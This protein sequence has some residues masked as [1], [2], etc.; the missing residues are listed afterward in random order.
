MKKIIVVFALAIQT[1]YIAAMDPLQTNQPS[2]NQQP[3]DECMEAVYSDP[4]GG[5]VDD[6]ADM[7]PFETEQLPPIFDELES[8]GQQ[9]HS[10][11]KPYID[12]KIESTSRKRKNAIAID[13]LAHTLGKKRIRETFQCEKCHKIISERNRSRHM[14]THETER[15]IKCTVPGC[16]QTFKRNET[17]KVHIRTHTG[18]KRYKCPKPECGKAFSQK[19]NLSTHVKMVHDKVMPYFCDECQKAFSTKQN[20]QV[21]LQTKIHFG[22]YTCPTCHIIFASGTAFGEHQLSYQH[23]AS[24]SAIRLGLAQQP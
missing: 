19:G 1:M 7:P 15:P 23:D 24:T 5:I 17:L 9:S 2:D 8:F 18:E 14:G 13:A 16:G 21:H 4:R 12:S 10:D 22:K 20:L 11:E 6:L 3:D